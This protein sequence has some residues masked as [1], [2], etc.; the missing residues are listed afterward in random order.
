MLK[1]DGYPASNGQGGLHAPLPDVD[2]IAP[3]SPDF[4]SALPP[5]SRTTAGRQRPG[6]VPR[7]ELARGTAEKEVLWICRAI[8]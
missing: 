8:Q 1:T 2:W 3:E 7:A 6:A 4:C 5:R